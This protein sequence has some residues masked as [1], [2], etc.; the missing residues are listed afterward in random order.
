MTESQ[1]NCM[2]PGNHNLK[3]PSREEFHR[4]ASSILSEADFSTEYPNEYTVRRIAQSLRWTVKNAKNHKYEVWP[5]HRK[6]TE[7][8]N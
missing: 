3:T 6:D 5:R 8:V 2:T 7:N 4:Y 1:T